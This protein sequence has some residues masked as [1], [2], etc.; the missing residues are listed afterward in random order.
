MFGKKLLA[1]CFIIMFAGPAFGDT[2]ALKADHPERYVVKKGDTL[3][4]ISA[5][6]LR[7]PWRW[8]D[9][10]EFNPQIENPHLIYPGD[11]IILTYR[12]GKPILSVQRGGEQQIK[13]IKLTPKVRKIQVSR[14]I[15]TIPI[16]AI[17]QFLAKPRVISEREM[18]NSP[19]IV[20]SKGEHLIVGSDDEIYARGI[21]QGKDTQYSVFRTGRAWRCR[22]FGMS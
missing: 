19:Y 22:P 15:P 21:P 4:D 9:V 13:T 3:W 2:I 5:R 20:S 10:W 11:V 6:F 18:M 17:K 14:A 7:D 8:P 16:S 1:L 12:E